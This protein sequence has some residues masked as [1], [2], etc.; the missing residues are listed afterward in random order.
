MEGIESNSNYIFLMVTA[1]VITNSIGRGR[2]TLLS[3]VLFRATT[4]TVRWQL[5][6]SHPVSLDPCYQH[7]QF[8]VTMNWFL[9]V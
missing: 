3:T 5:A 6:C 1:V 9:S 8:P 2:E 7:K 4:T